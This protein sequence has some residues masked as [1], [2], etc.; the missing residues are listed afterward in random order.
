MLMYLCEH[1]SHLGLTLSSQFLPGKDNEHSEHINKCYIIT[2]IKRSFE[3][4][5]SFFIFSSYFEI[6]I[7]F[8]KV[9]YSS[10]QEEQLK[11][12]M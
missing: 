10:N 11:R 8:S 1:V 9:I 6:I 7:H 2:T 12:T 5:S 3:I 4:S